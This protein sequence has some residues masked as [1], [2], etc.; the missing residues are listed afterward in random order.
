[1]KRKAF[2]GSIAIIILFLI[3]CRGSS[4]VA[5]A[6][7]KPQ[8]LTS[9]MA[10]EWEPAIG[11]I[12]AWPLGIPHKLAV[13]LANDTRLYTMVPNEAA[14]QD[15]QYWFAE[16]GI[17]LEKI[18]FIVAPQ[19]VDYWWLRD[20]GPHA[21]FE[22]SGMKLAN[23]QYPNSTPLSGLECDDELEFF[24]TKKDEETG[25]EIVV[26]TTEEDKAPL[27]I[28]QAVNIDMIDLPFV[29]TGGNV[30]TD[31]RGTAFSSC[32]IVNEN[33]YMGLDKDQFF[34]EAESLLGISDYHLLSNFELKGIQHVDC[35]MKM[36]DEERLLVTRPP[37]DHELSP[38][39]EN[40]VQNEL[41]SLKNCYGRPYQILRLDTERYEGNLLAAY[42][43]SLILNQTVY[44]PLFSIPQ[45]SI[46]LQQWQAA[47]P[48]Y[49]IK[50]FEFIMDEE[51][52][53]SEQ[54]R[55][56]YPGKIGWTFG[57]ALHCRT[58]AM[59]DPEMLYISVD[60]VPEKTPES[61]SMLLHATIIDY[62]GKGLKSNEL[63]L[64]WKFEN[65]DSWT[66]VLLKK[67][68]EPHMFIATIPVT[69]R[70]EN[71]TYYVSAASESGRRELMPR[72]GT[73]G[74]YL[75]F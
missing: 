23:G 59:W 54:V 58:R 31:G 8:T 3:S 26:P 55:N 56:N 53:L 24:F 32:I 75:L 48:G 57:D 69:D 60:R 47:M 16:W 67:A 61:D 64:F 18:Q 10:A 29:F 9:R 45:D 15:A 66:E 35:F 7:H 72:V 40:I 28:G 17:D 65:H 42:T 39:Y 73:Q 22:G 62:S 74:P 36:L 51:P 5:Q 70:G 2:L 44:V 13:E 21:V 33:Q 20:W 46:A 49:T 27:N 30:L 34:K 41:S 68:S 38:I 6:N 63:K 14:R 19:G 25:A 4:E 37:Q 71:I 50:G 12:I 52:I 43:N 1:M 11:V